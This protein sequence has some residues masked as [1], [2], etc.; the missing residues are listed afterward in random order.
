MITRLPPPPLKKKQ[1]LHVAY[2]LGAW[3]R[4]K[5]LTAPDYEL[6]DSMQDKR[7]FIALQS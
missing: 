6:S 5:A 4:S 1:Y 7:D 2:K 3:G